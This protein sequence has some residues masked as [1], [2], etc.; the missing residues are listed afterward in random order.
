MKKKQLIIVFWMCVCCTP[1]KKAEDSGSVS[2]SSDTF[3]IEGK[4]YLKEYAIDSL[5]KI[6]EEEK[7]NFEKGKTSNGQ[8]ILIKTTLHVSKNSGWYPQ[9]QLTIDAFISDNGKFNKLLWQI[10][11]PKEEPDGIWGKFYKTVEHGCCDAENGYTLYNLN[12]GQEVLTFSEITKVP[13]NYD[14]IAY[15]SISTVN[16]KRE[17]D[18]T[19]VGKIKQL[20]EEDRN[21]TSYMVYARPP[22]G[23][24]AVAGIAMTP[25]DY[26]PAISIESKSSLLTSGF[27]KSFP[28]YQKGERIQKLDT[29][30]YYLVLKYYDEPNTVLLPIEKDQIKANELI[31]SS[32]LLS[33]CLLIKRE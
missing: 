7:V 14:F 16:F 5:T 26:T 19:V 10:D 11:K 23:Q 21:I 22:V 33:E 4:T 1:E 32:K 31:S 28:L 9:Y 24:E 12:D 17:A 6:T 8:E 30:N 25:T 3:R 20:H 18:S 27:F 29:S 15:Q 13:F 2:N